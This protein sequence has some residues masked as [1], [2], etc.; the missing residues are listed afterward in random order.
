[1]ADHTMFSFGSSPVGIKQEVPSRNGPS[2]FSPLPAPPQESQSNGAAAAMLQ[3][4]GQEQFQRVRTIMMAQQRTFVQQLYELHKLN[5]LQKLLSYEVLGFEQGVGLP[6][7]PQQNPTPEPYCQPTNV[8]PY[9]PLSV[10]PLTGVCVGGQ[11]EVD[12]SGQGWARQQVLPQGAC[13]TAVPSQLHHHH[14]LQYHHHQHHHQHHEHHHAHQGYPHSPEQVLQQQLQQQ[15]EIQVHAESG[16]GDKCMPHSPPP[17]AQEQA[18]APVHDV[19]QQDEVGGHLQQQKVVDSKSHG[20]DQ[21]GTCGQRQVETDRS[22]EWE[23]PER[24]DG[25]QR[26]QEGQQDLELQHPLQRQEATDSLQPAPLPPCSQNLDLATMPPA[27]SCNPPGSTCPLLHIPSQHPVAPQHSSSRTSSPLRSRMTSPISSRPPSAQF[28]VAHGTLLAPGTIYSRPQSAEVKGS[29]FHGLVGLKYNPLCRSAGS[30]GDPQPE[31]RARDQLALHS[32]VA[33][34]LSDAMARQQL[35]N[36][37]EQERSD[38]PIGNLLGQPPH[39]ARPAENYDQ[40]LLYQLPQGNH[41]PHH[42]ARTATL[43]SPTVPSHVTHSASVKGHPRTHPHVHRGHSMSSARQDQDDAMPS[44]L[45]PAQTVEVKHGK[46]WPGQQQDIFLSV[47]VG[48]EK[49][50]SLSDQGS[51]DAQDTRRPGPHGPHGACKDALIDGARHQQQQHGMHEVPQALSR[52]QAISVSQLLGETPATIG[53]EGTLFGG[54]SSYSTLLPP[55]H[56]PAL[57]SSPANVPLPSCAGCV[58]GEGPLAESTAA[59]RQSKRVEERSNTSLRALKSIPRRVYMSPSGRVLLH[60]QKMISTGSSRQDADCIEFRSV[61]TLASTA[62]MRA[63][64]RRSPAS[65]SQPPSP[66]PSSQTPS[67]ELTPRTPLSPRLLTSRLAASLPSSQACLTNPLHNAHTTAPLQHLL[68]SGSEDSDEVVFGGDPQDTARLQE[69]YETLPQGGAG[70]DAGSEE[71]HHHPAHPARLAQVAAASQAALSRPFTSPALRIMTSMDTPAPPL[72]SYT[73]KPCKLGT[74]DPH[75]RPPTRVGASGAVPASPHTPHWGSTQLARDTPWA[76]GSKHTPFSHLTSSMG[77][78]HPRAPVSSASSRSQTFTRPE[79]RCSRTR[80][81]MARGS[82]A[83][84][85]E[86]SNTGTLE[87]RAGVGTKRHM[88]TPGLIGDTPDG[89]FFPR[90]R[91][92]SGAVG[93]RTPSGPTCSDVGDSRP[94]SHHGDRPLTSGSSSSRSPSAAGLQRTGLRMLVAQTVPGTT[95]EEA[96]P[97][98][99]PPLLDQQES[100]ASW[101]SLEAKGRARP[102][103]AKGPPLPVSLLQADPQYQDFDEELSEW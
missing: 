26:Q 57:S 14:H 103:V 87:S 71:A 89:A 46:K 2:S 54:G 44:C 52:K 99:I 15:Q 84:A 91:P 86:H 5:Q 72:P 25:A 4:L 79:R 62:R 30:V 69:P 35:L 38:T 42:P 73:T 76:S 22:C 96:A 70:F 1:M 94:G 31:E 49:G 19:P 27:P 53:G 82:A 33:H 68:E 47:P 85:V 58:A 97:V 75:L 102:K 9:P 34:R 67:A 100:D 45:Q 48:Q 95:L 55:T 24:F 90:G 64:L 3:L 61:P 39:I 20:P 80:L 60:P 16:Q 29:P 77:R 37:G 41:T 63:H 50:H 92:S 56:I 7:P 78:S 83:N 51:D 17:E 93:T 23:P 32:Q 59:G 65:T 66:L 6:A 88:G 11:E 10:A 21:A 74:L 8:A 98:E 28:R 18:T 43:A 12:T 40:V 36:A 13:L 101:E 81:G